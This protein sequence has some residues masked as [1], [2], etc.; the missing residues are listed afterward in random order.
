MVLSMISQANVAEAGKC[1]GSA[2]RSS[3]KGMDPAVNC[4]KEGYE[5]HSVAVARLHSSPLLH[6]LP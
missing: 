4:C 6:A 1:A 5:R 2:G 3:Q